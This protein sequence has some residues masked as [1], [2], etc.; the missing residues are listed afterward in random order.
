[1]QRCDSSKHTLTLRSST[2]L[3]CVP[4]LAALLL[5]MSDK[6]KSKKVAQ[7][8]IVEL[9][10]GG[11]VSRSGT[12]GSAKA[13]DTREAISVLHEAIEALTLN[14]QKNAVIVAFNRVVKNYDGVIKVRC[15][16]CRCC[17][18]CCYR[19]CCCC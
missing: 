19:C 6:K 7:K 17:C 15:C 14:E 11:K 10:H 8:E 13:A 18:C 9:Q 5:Q 16:C 3:C 1:M 12:K 2:P 4:C